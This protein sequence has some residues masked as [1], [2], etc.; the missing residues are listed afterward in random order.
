[1]N[2]AFYLLPLCF[3]RDRCLYPRCVLGLERV[4]SR[5]PGVETVPVRTLYL[6]PRSQGRIQCCLQDLEGD[7]VIPPVFTWVFVALLPADIQIDLDNASCRQMLNH[8]LEVRSATEL[9]NVLSVCKQISVRQA[10]E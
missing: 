10:D 9:E 7:M 1:M 8:A 5:F 2:H 3:C 6:V 4:P